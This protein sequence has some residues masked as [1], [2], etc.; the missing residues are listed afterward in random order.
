MCAEIDRKSFLDNTPVSDLGKLPS[1]P[2]KMSY[3]FPPLYCSASLSYEVWMSKDN[4][5][6]IFNISKTLMPNSV[7]SRTTSKNYTD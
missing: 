7:G 2:A 6:L 5:L 3:F 4:K 1:T